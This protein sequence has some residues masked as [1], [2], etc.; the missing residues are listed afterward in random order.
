M[1]TASAPGK[2]LLLG[3]YVV[4]DGAPALVMAVQRRA[5]VRVAP[6]TEGFVLSAPQFG[7]HSVSLNMAN[8]DEARVGLVSCLVRDVRLWLAER[9]RTLPEL[10][11]EIDTLSFYDGETKLGMGSSAAVTAALWGAC[12]R[13]ASDGAE[14]A[15]MVEPAIDA[16]RAAQGGM[17]SGADVAASLLGG[18]VRFEI[19]EAPAVHLV[20]DGLRLAA[21]WTG[22]AASTPEMVAAVQRARGEAEVDSAWAELE[23]SVQPLPNEAEGWV[24]AVAQASRGMRQLGDAA[25]V[26]IETEAHRRIAWIAQS[27]GWVS[28][29]SGAGGGDYAILATAD[30]RSRKA[31]CDALQTAG[32]P[33][34]PLDGN[35]PGLIVGT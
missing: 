29:P 5:H 27:L 19:G 20:P 1:I 34:L 21:A 24:A 33:S 12:C 16:H 6:S 22:Q 15:D 26:A 7:M 10:N 17:G 28:K 4:L 11:I 30:N 31:L 9:D 14:A 35:E 23:A 18:V 8:K 3:D 2:L 32:F 13:A 25:G